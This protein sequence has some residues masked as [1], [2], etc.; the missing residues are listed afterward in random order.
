MDGK[1]WMIIALIKMCIGVID[2][3][4]MVF[5]HLK[6]ECVVLII[7]DEMMN[8]LWCLINLMTWSR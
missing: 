5:E 6:C 2:V 7:Y 8:I 1:Y 4:W 3:L